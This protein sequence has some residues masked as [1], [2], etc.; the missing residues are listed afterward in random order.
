M[1]VRYQDD[2]GNV[3]DVPGSGGNALEALGWTRLD[4]PSEDESAKSARKT[5][6]VKPTE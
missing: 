6:A 4:E 2:Q 3:L 5:R 1:G